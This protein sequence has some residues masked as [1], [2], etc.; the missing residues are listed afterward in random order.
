MTLRSIVYTSWLVAPEGP[1]AVAGIVRAAR[2]KN[3]A[4]GITGALIFDG[5]RFCQYLEGEDAEVAQTFVAI[6]RDVRHDRVQVLLDAP[7]DKLRFARWAM[8]FAVSDATA[9][10]ETLESLP[11]GWV[12]AAF[13]E[14]LALCDMDQ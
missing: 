3:A 4:R 1:G 2:E 11:A 12:A 10:I 8:G 7:A 6:G 9:L 14:G 5:E 13:E